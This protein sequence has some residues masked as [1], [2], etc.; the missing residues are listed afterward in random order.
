L[1]PKFDPIADVYDRWYDAPEGRAIFAAELKCLRALCGHF[2]DRWVEV[3]VGT[4]RF[5]SMLGIGEGIDPS[6]RMLEISDRFGKPQPC[7]P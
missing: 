2:N 7:F 5:A 1:E 4:G 3:G 6:L